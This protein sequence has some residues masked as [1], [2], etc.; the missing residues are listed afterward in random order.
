MVRVYSYICFARCSAISCSGKRRSS[1]PLSLQLSFKLII[2]PDGY[3]S[4]MMLLEQCRSDERCGEHI[5][6]Y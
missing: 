4:G 5:S 1:A 3:M 6:L 2:C